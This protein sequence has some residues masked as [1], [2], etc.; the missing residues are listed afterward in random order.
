M[1]KL[2]VILFALAFVLSSCS[3]QSSAS[4]TPVVIVITATS[5]P[6]LARPTS[7]EAPTNTPLPT[8]TVIPSPIP[9]DTPLPTPT[10]IPSPI[11]TNTPLPTPTVVPSSTP[12]ETPLPTQKPVTFAEFDR[13]LRD[14]GYSRDTF[15]A[16]GKYS[17]LRPG[18]TGYVY[19]SSN[20]WAPIKAYTDGY[21]RLEVVNDPKHRAED[22]EKKF[23]MLDDLFPADFM[24]EL[25]KAN[26]AYLE[27]LPNSVGISGEL[28]KS[29][30]APAKDFWN[31]FEAQYNVSN[32]TFGP[33]PV[34]FSLWYWQIECPPGYICWIP[35]FPSEVFR[36]QNSITFYDI[37]IT[38]AP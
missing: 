30:P 4:P 3:F 18:K 16:I 21:V 11:P 33:Y 19:I 7:T 6:F 29:W 17:D 36:G 26:D 24:T 8:P 9:T 15:K 34:G 37:E 20:V 5:R 2:I 31:S 25:R 27:S 1:K 32:E 22:M 38:I 23:K 10:V 14:N 35:S 28:Y 12:T 13:L